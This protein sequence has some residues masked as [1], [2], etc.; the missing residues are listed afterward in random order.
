MQEAIFHKDHEAINKQKI[1]TDGDA[2]K[3]ERSMM[4]NKHT[5][6]IT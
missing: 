5:C 2:K 4:N 1:S 6:L 3:T